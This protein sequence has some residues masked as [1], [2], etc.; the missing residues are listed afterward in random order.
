MC[1]SIVRKEKNSVIKPSV[2]V[3]KSNDNEKIVDDQ[4]LASFCETP[5]VCLQTLRIKL[6]SQTREK[7]V[8][9]IFDT[10][11]QRS[12][13]RTDIAREL[14][15]VSL[16]ELKVSHSLFDGIKSGSEIHNMFKTRI[17]NLDK[18]YACNFS[19][20]NQDT[21]CAPI[22]NIKRDAWVDELQ[23]KN[24]NLTDIGGRSN[25]IEVQIGA[26]VAGKL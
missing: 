15:Y 19:A 17:Q 11:S 1:P 23:A 14:G 26:D 6:C 13:I 16:G 8:S 12:Y 4:N 21:I 2:S 9:V 7:I 18:S 10:A 3:N 20:M 25:S 5:D 22:A 24:I